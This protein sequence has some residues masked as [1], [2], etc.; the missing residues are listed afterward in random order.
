GFLYLGRRALGDPPPTVFEWRNAAI[1]GVF[2][3]V[4]G[5][6]GV[7][8]AEQF[9]TSSL[10]ALVVATV[11]LWIVLFEG[12][13]PGGQRPDLMALFSVLIGFSGVVLLVGSAGGA[14]DTMSVV[15]LAVL[16][17]ASLSW[18]GG[19]LYARNAGLPSSPLLGTAME[20]LAGG[21]ALLLLA[22]AH[23]EWTRLDLAAVSTRSAVALVY[24][25]VIGSA[26]F[27]AYAWLLRVAPTSLVATYAY[28][29]PLVA[30]VLGHVLADETVGLRT[31]TAGALIVGAVALASM[32]KHWRAAALERP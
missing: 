3:L 20:M 9:V 29:N 18:A 25:T 11:P 31:I 13:R 14:A 12:L 26:G 4:G 32:P 15:G 28:V 8:W 21:M 1:I 5:N 17:L 16:V 7:V 30:V 24:L 2:L 19:S 23:G 6:G 10:A 27:V 22:S